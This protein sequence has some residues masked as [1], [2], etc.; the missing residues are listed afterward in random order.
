M[1]YQDSDTQELKTE[2][3]ALEAYVNQCD[4]NIR[5]A[6]PVLMGIRATIE[7]VDIDGTTIPDARRLEL[8]TALIAKS[9][10]VRSA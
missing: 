10:E 9:K 6:R 5:E 2:L 8:K 1:S 3:Q 4:A 7:S